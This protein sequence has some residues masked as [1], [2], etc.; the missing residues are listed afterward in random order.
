MQ[1]TQKQSLATYTW[2]LMLSSD[3]QLWLKEEVTHTWL[4]MLSPDGELWLEENDPFSHDPAVLCF[5]MK[6]PWIITPVITPI[7][8]ATIPVNKQKLFSG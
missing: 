1:L 2:L 5:L 7:A 8:S 6:W 4:M 3:G